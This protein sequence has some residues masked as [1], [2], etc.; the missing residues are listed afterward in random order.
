MQ[1]DSF[2][3]MEELRL[4]VFKHRENVDRFCDACAALPRRDRRKVE[5]I[6]T[7]RSCDKT[8]A[9]EPWS[10]S[11][12]WECYEE[13]RAIS[14]KVATAWRRC[15]LDTMEVGLARYYVRLNFRV[16]AD[17]LEC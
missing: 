14:P 6:L 8:G 12:M 3:T 5:R 11:E 17:S 7:K 10:K 2:K 15:S 13:M 4:E 1:D 16:L 9:R